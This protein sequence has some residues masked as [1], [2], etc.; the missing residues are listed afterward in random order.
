MVSEL[1]Y[2]LAE[3]YRFWSPREYGL[4]FGQMMFEDAVRRYVDL[5]MHPST[6]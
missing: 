5:K 1:V 3:G 4:E 2:R 6:L